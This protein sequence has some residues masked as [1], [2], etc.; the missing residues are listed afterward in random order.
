MPTILS[1]LLRGGASCISNAICYTRNMNTT[2]PFITD[3]KSN[4]HPA[5]TV[6]LCINSFNNV[7]GVGV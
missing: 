3:P 6:P 4:Y 7:D 2:I 1:L 5:P